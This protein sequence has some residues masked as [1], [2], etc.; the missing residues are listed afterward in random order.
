MSDALSAVAK[1]LVPFATG[2]FRKLFLKVAPAAMKV[3]AR[4]SGWSE[5]DYKRELR[6]IGQS[7]RLPDRD[8][9]DEFPLVPK[10]SEE[11]KE[12]V[13][14]RP[15]ERPPKEVAA[16]PLVGVEPNPGP[17][18]KGGKKP[19]GKGKKGGAKGKKKHTPDKKLKEEIN[20]AFKTR[21]VPTSSQ[22]ITSIKPYYYRKEVEGKTK[23]YSLISLGQIYA[24]SAAQ[25][26]GS[27]IYS[28]AINK[29]LFSG[30]QVG[31]DFGCFEMYRIASGKLKFLSSVNS[32]VSGSFVMFTDP[33]SVDVLEPVSTT[34]NYNTFTTHEGAVKE[35][36]YQDSVVT[37]KLN[38]N[39]KQLYTDVALTVYSNNGA[40]TNNSG[41]VRFWTAGVINIVSGE[42]ITAPVQ[43]GELF[44]ETV[45]EWAK[46]QRS[47]MANFI[48]N[49]RCQAGASQSITTISATQNWNPITNLILSNNNNNNAGP[50]TG[51]GLEYAFNPS[52]LSNNN[53]NGALALPQGVYKM[54][55]NISGTGQATFNAT[56]KMNNAF[57][58]NASYTSWSFAPFPTTGDNVT[59]Y[60][61]IYPPNNPNI[62]ATSTIWW[63]SDLRLT[64]TG[65]Y[66]GNVATWTP[67]IQF[68]VTSGSFVVTGMSVQIVRMPSF[69][70]VPVAILFPQ[71][72]SSGIGAKR[73]TA[74]DLL[75][76]LEDEDKSPYIEVIGEKAPNNINTG[77]KEQ[78]KSLLASL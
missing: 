61:W 27:V 31:D 10:K 73:K 11:R 4:A 40:V 20:R 21:V 39:R 64:G 25:H 41:D 57:S 16:P 47:E 6:K 35:K 19:K 5:K 43:M 65:N 30:T 32:T 42:G 8:E 55:G 68:T 53:P 13:F 74:H 49:G 67:Q 29:N 24:T 76:Q 50:S 17:K 45:I 54:F 46:P 60:E 44:L 14:R 7:L 71:G 9:N 70:T 26:T 77:F 22:L 36:L 78:L 1:N 38:C 52:F 37:V 48:L 15:S 72:S 58:S 3:A 12:K 18:P 69:D 63:G 59:G 2:P 62:G 75:L 66:G 33:D 51:G 56:V 23:S 34:L 28:T